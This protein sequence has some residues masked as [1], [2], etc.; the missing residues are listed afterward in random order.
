M[1]TTL[2]INR[3]AKADDGIYA[4]DR[5]RPLC[6]EG[7]EIHRQAMEELKNLGYSVEEILCSPY[8]R[9]QQTAEIAAEF[10]GGTVKIDEALGSDFNAEYLVQQIPPPKDNKTLMFVGHEPTL[11]QFANALV[12]EVCLPAGLSKSSTVIITFDKEIAFGKGTF[13]TYLKP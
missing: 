11:S 8:L 5:D 7:R 6:D 4:D 10:V 9:A 3:H 2:I 12:G 13:E 1:T